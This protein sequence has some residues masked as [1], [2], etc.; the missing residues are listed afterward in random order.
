MSVLF[1]TITLLTVIGIGCSASAR[2]R[3]E[4][5]TRSRQ[6]KPTAVDKNADRK[7]EKNADKSSD[8]QSAAAQGTSVVDST[9]IQREMQNLAEQIQLL[10]AEVKR[11]RRAT[12]TNSDTAELLLIEERLGK[13]EDKIDVQQDKKAALDARELESQTR[14]RNIQQ[15]L[16]LRGG[17]RRDETE[18]AIR[19]EV[20]RSRQDIQDQR[21]TIQQR[22]NDLQSR[23]SRLRARVE[24]LQKKTEKPQEK[25]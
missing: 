22:L 13:V 25:N 14:L 15:E 17:L 20:Q 5:G 1:R 11:L 9:V 21:T 2:D 4:S 23:A 6:T 7:T 19:A 8:R 10:T 18:A 24:E 16:L 12:E 3:Q